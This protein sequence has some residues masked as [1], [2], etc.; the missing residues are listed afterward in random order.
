MRSFCLLAALAL[1]LSSCAPAVQAPVSRPAAPA[2][3]ASRVSELADAYLAAYLKAFPENATWASM[4]GARHDRLTDNSPEGLRAWHEAED[5]L[6]AAL[7]G[8]DPQPLLG[9]PDWV[10]FGFLNEALESSRGLRVCHNELWPANQMT[11]WQSGYAQLAAAQPVGTPDLRAQALERWR[12]MPRFIDQEIANLREGIRLGYS[13]PKRSVALVIEQ[14]DG[15]LVL[16]PEQSPFYSPAERDGDPAFRKA[17]MEL[18][19]DGL[20]PAAERYRAYLRDE[21]LPAAR[22]PLAVSANP[23]GA[24]CYVASLRAYTTLEDSPRAVFERGE[25]AVA[26]REARMKEIGRELY[27]T[28]DLEEIRRRMSTDPADRFSSRDE[29][30][31]YSRAAVERAK[32]A[33]PRWFGRVPRAD[34]V[35]RP[36]PELAEKSSFS[37]YLPASEDGSRPGTYEINLYR[38]EDQRRSGVES[39]AF[40]ETWPGHHLQIALAQERGQAHPVTRYLFNSGFVEGWARYCETTLAGEMGLHSS[41][42]N[43]LSAQA[44]LPAGMVIDP[45]LHALGWTRQQAIDYILSKRPSITPERAATAVDRISVLPGQLT[46]YDVGEQEILTLRDEARQALGTRFDVRAFHDRVLENG[47][48]TLGMLREVIRHWIGTESASL[49]TR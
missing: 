39:T 12:G 1:A 33:V 20:Y 36:Q 48:I 38:P 21:Y 22:E 28:G 43:R 27:G 49:S 8:V 37:Q 9:T 18:L 19:R 44:A 24:A 13:T 10:T 26:A 31:S 4:P 41:D 6:A 30:L 16:P 35:I 32:R 34:V 15:L 42:F 2:A 17:W 25:R 11:G 45:G 29:I 5:R 40:H 23:D 46:S 14:L 3:T 7:A 47:S